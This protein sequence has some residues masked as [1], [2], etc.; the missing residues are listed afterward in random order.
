MKPISNLLENFERISMSHLD[1]KKETSNN[2][3]EMIEKEKLLKIEINMLM[4]Q[5]AAEAE[6]KKL[7]MSKISIYGNSL[8]WKITSPIRKVGKSVRN[9]WN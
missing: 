4:N 8:S 5:L 3:A 9:L 2:I 6:E 1:F 7:L